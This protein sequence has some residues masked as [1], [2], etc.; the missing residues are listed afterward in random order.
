MI[1]HLVKQTDYQVAYLCKYYNVSRSGYYAWQNRPESQRA[2]DNRQ[3]LTH[4]ASIHKRSHGTYGSP[5][6]TAALNR[7]GIRCGENRIAR[8]MREQ[9]LVGK[10]HQRYRH[11]Q[12]TNRFFQRFGNLRLNRSVPNAPNQVWAG[13]ITYLQLHKHYYYLAVIM[14]VYSRKVI[15]WSLGHQRSVD[16]TLSVL[17][18]AIKQR[19]PDTG[20]IF[21][22]DRG[23]EYASYRYE[24]ELKQHGI[25]PS[26]NR[27]GH[28]VDNAHVESFFHT[29][30]GEWLK[31]KTF[32]SFNEL[33]QTIQY[34]IQQFYNGSRL[35]SGI[36]YY[37]P[38]EY[39]RLAS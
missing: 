16:L 7:Q 9:R 36:G 35:H 20:L 6:I 25:R 4:I 29:M 21:H 8:L 37:S 27:P 17:R 24:T 26:M 28:C 10:I 33:K 5:R 23:I 32:K 31:G 19:Q 2:K 22:S 15:A 11:C 39:E 1:H 13:D 30:K 34:Y 12:G 38:N 18:Q 3:L 14:D